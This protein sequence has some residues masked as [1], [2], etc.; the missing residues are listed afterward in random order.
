MSELAAQADPRTQTYQATLIMPQPEGVNILPG[1]TA[2]VS[3]RVDAE[4]DDAPVVVPAVAV[5]GD[6]SGSAHVWVLD[7]DAMTV[8]KRDVTTGNLVGTDRIRIVNG[9]GDGEM[10]AV[11]AVSRLREGMAVRKLGE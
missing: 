3:A 8:H 6:D 10:I 11:S 1:M 5:A 2:L 4:L 7:Q 9:L